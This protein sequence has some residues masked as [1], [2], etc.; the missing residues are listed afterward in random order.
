M[1]LSLIEQLISMVN[2]SSLSSLEI[3][4]QG[5]RIRLENQTIYPGAPGYL[6]DATAA[7]TV[8][9]GAASPNGAVFP[10]VAA[11]PQLSALLHQSAAS[12]SQS[13]ETAAEEDYI[14]IKSP[15]VGTYH[16]VQTLGYDPLEPGDTVK[17][18]QTVCAVEAMKLMNVIEAEAAGEIVEFMAEDGALVEYGQNLVKMR[19][20]S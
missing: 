1:D 2:M 5:L 11:P 9:L 3:E 20:P 13:Q 8:G 7:G 15:L 18:G 19:N 6:S 12:V 10:S 16:S 17:P 4:E 14:Y